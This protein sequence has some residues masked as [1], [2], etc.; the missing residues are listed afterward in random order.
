VLRTASGERYLLAALMFLEGPTAQRLSLM[1]AESE[2]GARFVA[3]GYLAAGRGK[4]AFE[5]SR[6]LFIHRRP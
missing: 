6:C 2:R 5:P 4:K 1:A 3:R